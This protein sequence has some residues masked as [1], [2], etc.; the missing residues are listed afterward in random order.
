MKP[1]TDLVQPGLEVPLLGGLPP[2]G[3][4]AAQPQEGVLLLLLLGVGGRHSG[5]SA[6]LVRARGSR[7]S[8]R[9]CW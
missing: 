3:G 4:H 7:S 2:A 1:G 5:R 9:S 6:G 8:A